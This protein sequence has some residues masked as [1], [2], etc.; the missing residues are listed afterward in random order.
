MAPELLDWK[1]CP[2][3]E[4]DIYALGMVIYEVFRIAFPCGGGPNGSLSQVFAH[5]RP[6]SHVPNCAAPGLVLSGMRPTRPTNRE[7][8]GLS[9]DLWTLTK[10]CW[11]LV[12]GTRPDAADVLVLVETASRGWV[13]PPSEEIASLNIDDRSTD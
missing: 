4:S 9:E 7:I 6:F 11:D 12:P 13:S 10:R 1:T 2:S 8:L 5:Q 3:R